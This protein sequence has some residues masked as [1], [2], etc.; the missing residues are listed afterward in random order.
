MNIRKLLSVRNNQLL[1]RYPFIQVIGTIK[2]LLLSALPSFILLAYAACCPIPLNNIPS[3]SVTIYFVI[4][5]Y[6]IVM[7]YFFYKSLSYNALTKD[8]LNQKNY[9]A[10]LYFTYLI[11]ACVFFSLLFAAESLLNKRIISADKDKG[12]GISRLFVKG[13]EYTSPS[14]TDSTYASTETVNY[15]YS[16][17]KTDFAGYKKGVQ[18]YTLL[19]PKNQQKDLR[20]FSNIN[21]QNI[22]QVESYVNTTDKLIASTYFTSKDYKQVADTINYFTYGTDYRRLLLSNMDS[23]TSGFRDS[24]QLYLMLDTILR[25][26]LGGIG[27]YSWSN[28]SNLKKIETAVRDENRMS[29]TLLKYWVLMNSIITFCLLIF[30]FKLFEVKIASSVTFLSV[31]IFIGIMYLEDEVEIFSSY[32]EGLGFNRDERDFLFKVAW[33]AIILVILLITS[34]FHHFFKLF[35]PVFCLV[36]LLLLNTFF[37]SDIDSFTTIQ[38]GTYNFLTSLLILPFLMY[39]IYIVYNI[40]T[41]KRYIYE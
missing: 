30:I 2:V 37:G 21:L 1:V 41:K 16:R 13:F 26:S 25:K 12:V 35:V 15:L 38:G 18:N 28:F 7:L 23:F 22:K 33:M 39:R 14:S 9:L 3:L 32:F 19:Y 40:P 4:T 11:S 27:N 20:F 6:F 36:S 17:I 10:I 8:A 29:E 5:C 24:V 34:F 31:A